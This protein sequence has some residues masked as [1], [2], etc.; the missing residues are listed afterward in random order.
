[1]KEYVIEGGYP[2]QGTVTASGNKNAALPCLTATLLTT[3]P[4][5]LHNIPKIQDT[6]GVTFL[7]GNNYMYSRPYTVEVPAEFTGDVSKLVVGITISNN[8][9]NQQ[10]ESYSGIN[11]DTY[12]SMSELNKTNSSGENVQVAVYASGEIEIVNETEAGI[13]TTTGTFGL[14]GIEDNI[15]EEGN[16][17]SDWDMNDIV[18]Y[19][20]A[21][22]VTTI[23]YEQAAK[24]F[25]AFE[26]LGGTWDFDFN[27]VVLEID[28]VSGMESA[29]VKCV[30]AGG[31]LPVS[32]MYD[33]EERLLFGGEIHAA[34]DVPTTTVVNTIPRGQNINGLASATK[35]PLIDEV[36]VEEDFIIAPDAL[37][38][39]IF[40]DQ[41]TG[42]TFNQVRINARGEDG[43]PQALVIGTTWTK[44]PDTV[45]ETPNG[46]TVE[47]GQNVTN[48]EFDSW[49]WPIE[50]TAVDEAYPGITEWIQ[51]P[52]NLD[53]LK[54]GVAG[55]LY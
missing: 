42:S 2:I 37:P 52:T 54:T 8:Q 30:A 14:V 27:D 36:S 38:F 46:V 39:S 22:Q 50:C 9:Y 48:P 43:T 44:Y 1:M 45:V 19:T 24:Y 51:T 16:Y 10:G 11:N 26:D 25:V 21:T 41:A 4:V 53:W 55:K 5:V 23:E 34:F 18:L 33:P 20:E 12:Y 40:V 31:T 17:A 28:Y 15:N 29:L 49:R 3:E 32:V 13:E 6:Q 7:E 47:E 35:E